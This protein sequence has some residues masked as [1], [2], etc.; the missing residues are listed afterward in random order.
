MRKVGDKSLA[1]RISHLHEHDRKRRG[2]MAQGGDRRRCIGKDDVGLEA[3]QLCRISLETFGSPTGI[4]SSCWARANRDA[5][6][7]VPPK[8]MTIRSRRRM[9]A[10]AR[11]TSSGTAAVYHLKTRQ[12]AGI[13][14]PPG[15]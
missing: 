15:L 5:A 2:F 10:A 14:Y 6:T 11:K 3:D 8:S 12:G 7:A 4:R 1:E 13:G 9:S